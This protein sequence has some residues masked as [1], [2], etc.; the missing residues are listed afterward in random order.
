MECFLKLNASHVSFL[1]TAKPGQD[2]H[3]AI[4]AWDP[5]EEVHGWERLKEV[6][7]QRKAK[8]AAQKTPCQA[9]F[10]GGAIAAFE[11]GFSPRFTAYIYDHYAAWN[12]KTGEFFSSDPEFIEVTRALP[13]PAGKVP[14]RLIH[15]KAPFLKEKYREAFEK[16]QE[17]ILS[18]DIYQVN[19]THILHGETQH[20]TPQLFGRLCARHPSPMAAYWDGG[21]TQLLSLSPERF[22]SLKNDHLK[23][24][25]IKGTRPRG[26]TPEEDEKQKKALLDSEKEAAEL[27]MIT[28]LL[29]ND[30]GRVA[31]TGTVE[32]TTLR[33][34]QENP[35]VFHT[36]SVIEARL[37]PEL[38]AVDVLKATL[39]GGSISGCP[40][41]RACEI[42]AESETQ[43]RGLYTGVLAYLSDS[44]DMDSSILIRTLVHQNGDL[45]LGVGGGIVAD[46]ELEAEYQE[47]LDKAAPF[48]TL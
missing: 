5:V 2:D 37:K 22:L 20:P 19:L 34:I 26:H 9:P 6:H 24:N 23:T 35:S 21:S 15:W 47:T 14:K 27:N 31:Q 39:P 29:R 45:S 43:T 48:L 8:Y 10:C 3:W 42:I 16:I 17:Y 41:K 44:G 40:K 1:Y 25:P 36:Y 30:L 12:L 13:K 7:A 18:G 46:S 32:V 38:D 4:L 33:A 11:F 28:D